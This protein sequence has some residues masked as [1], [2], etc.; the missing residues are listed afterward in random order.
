MR[1]GNQS[2]LRICYRYDKHLAHRADIFVLNFLRVSVAE[3][4]EA[5]AGR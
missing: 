2:K 3:L 1:A 4:F 5:Q